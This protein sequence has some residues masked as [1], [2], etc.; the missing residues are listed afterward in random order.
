VRRR[1]SIKKIITRDLK[2]FHLWLGYVILLWI[3]KA[4]ILVEKLLGVDKEPWEITFTSKRARTTPITILIEGLDCSGKKTISRIL[5]KKL[6]TSG[7]SN[8]INIGPISNG[9]YNLISTLTRTKRFPDI[10]R[11]TVYFF[12]GFGDLLNIKKIKAEVFIQVSSPYRSLAYAVVNK[13]YIRVLASPILEKFYLNYDF[14][15]FITVPYNV[16]I[17]RHENQKNMG[18]NP[19]SI[20]ERFPGKSDFDRMEKILITKLKNVGKLEIFDNTQFSAE[21]IAEHIYKKINDVG[22]F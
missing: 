11:S 4:R 2:N 12:E 22:H 5:Q 1:I 13:L 14:I 20:N 10:I 18:Q 3:I 9:F 8:Q 16:R 19:H 15:F 7:I 6:L 21:N 17:T